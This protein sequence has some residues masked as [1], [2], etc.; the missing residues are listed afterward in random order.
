MNAAERKKVKRIVDSLATW[1][2]KAVKRNK[3]IRRLNL[4]IRKL[5]ESRNGWKNKALGR[6]SII[7]PLNQR[8]SRLKKSRDSWKAKSFR[9]KKAENTHNVIESLPA[10]SEKQTQNDQKKN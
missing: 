1:K 8:I 6:Q 9:M 4:K 5:E 2:N 3:D 7:R 10:D